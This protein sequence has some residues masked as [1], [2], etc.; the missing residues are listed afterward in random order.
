M[1]KA[2]KVRNQLAELEQDL[3]LYRL[4][5]RVLVAGDWNCKVGE[6]ASEVGDRRWTR[7]SVSDTVDSRGKHIMGMMNAAQ[8]V[9]LNGI[10]D[11]VA[12]YTCK[13]WQSAE[14][15][16]DRAL[17]TTLQPVQT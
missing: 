11:T 9:V 16:L 15:D 3:A 13:P 17:A 6:I 2:A 1:R 10:R 7:R 4:D 14:G 12:Q 8:M 5:G